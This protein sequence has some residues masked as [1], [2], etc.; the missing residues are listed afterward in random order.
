MEDEQKVRVRAAGVTLLSAMG[1]EDGVVAGL[2]SLKPEKQRGAAAAVKG[3]WEI[4]AEHG[5]LAG[6]RQRRARAEAA[7]AAPSPM[8]RPEPKE[9]KKEAPGEAP[10]IEAEQGLLTEGGRRRARAA[11]AEATKAKDDLPSLAT[12]LSSSG[13]SL[14]SPQRYS[15]KTST[16][17]GC[18][19]LHSCTTTA[20]GRHAA[21]GMGFENL[22]AVE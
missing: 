9:T 6:G 7:A 3:S 18:C 22:G 14:T 4:E 11:A 19:A 16:P 12:R 17:A 8:P 10:G 1:G 5:L 21:L 2:G 15:E 20:C 13:V